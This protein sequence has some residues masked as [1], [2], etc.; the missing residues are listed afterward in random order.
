[1]SHTTGTFPIA[2]SDPAYAYDR[3]PNTITAQSV[4]WS[5]PEKP[6]KAAKPT[7]TSL[8]AI[9]VLNDGV[10]LFNALDGEGRDAVAHELLDSC[11]D[12]PMQS[13]TLH[14]HDVPSCIRGRGEGHARR[15]SATPWTASAS[16][17]SATRPAS[18]SP[19]PISTRATAGRRRCSGTASS[20][21]CSTTTRRSSTRTRIGC[22]EGT[23][24][25]TNALVF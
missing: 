15:S 5:L 25:A 14:H 8:G 17:S 9:G 11:D 19:T 1:M 22:F 12:H 20:R 3:N 16:T 13:G 2:A 24:S 6:T 4:T 18:S 23:R 21:S 7:C 10:L